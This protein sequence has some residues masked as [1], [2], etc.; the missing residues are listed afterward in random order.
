MDSIV[1]KLRTDETLRVNL[2]SYATAV[3]DQALTARRVSMSRGLSVRNYLIDN[4]ISNT[5]INVLPE[6]DKNPG[7]EPDRVD[8][9]IIK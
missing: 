9:F 4:G 8:I 3:A 6:G 5:R 1:A 2:V 7:G